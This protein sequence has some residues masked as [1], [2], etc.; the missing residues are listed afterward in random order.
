MDWKERN[1]SVRIHLLVE[2]GRTLDIAKEIF[3]DL[4]YLSHQL[5][6]ILCN[7]SY[8]LLLVTLLVEQ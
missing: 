7:L 5:D 1:L 4:E 3:H 2:P 6:I 8:R